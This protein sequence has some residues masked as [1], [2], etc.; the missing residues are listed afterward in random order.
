LLG[1]P[2]P[3]PGLCQRHIGADQRIGVRDRT[4]AG[5]NADQYILELGQRAVLHRLLLQ[6]EFSKDRGQ[7]VC[8]R[9]TVAEHTQ[10]GEVR[11]L[12]HGH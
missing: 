12:A 6:L 10:R 4:A 8:P 2:L 9:Q 5:Q 1:K 11:R 7:K 3:P